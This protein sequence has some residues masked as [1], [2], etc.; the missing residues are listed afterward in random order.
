VRDALGLQQLA[1]QFNNL[2][3]GNPEIYGLYEDRRDIDGI[4]KPS[5]AHTQF[6]VLTPSLWEKH[7]LGRGNNRL[8]IVPKLSDGLCYFGAID[9]DVCGLHSPNLTK[10]AD[11]LASKSIPAVVCRSKSGGAH[12]YC[13]AKTPVTV[14]RM[15]GIL[16]KVAKELDLPAYDMFPKQN[17]AAWIIVPYYGGLDGAGGNYAV[18]AKGQ[19]LTADEF[20]ALAGQSCIVQDWAEKV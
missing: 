15:Q 17:H 8:G 2:F 20:L 5:H 10:L 18:A 19:R 12:V 3:I 13:F 11:T 9:V 16:G 6:A 14:L 7:L 4:V 1:I